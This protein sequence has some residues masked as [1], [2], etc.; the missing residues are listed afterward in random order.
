VDELKQDLAAYEEARPKLLAEAGQYALFF[1]GKH[2]GNFES[3]SQALTKGYEIAGVEPF[4]VQQ[5]SPLPQILHFTRAMKF[6]E[7]PT[8][9]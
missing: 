4:L 7:C 6:L 9:S 3:Y 1:K 5:I 2:V 8:S